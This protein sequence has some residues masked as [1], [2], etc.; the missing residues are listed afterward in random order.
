M[1]KAIILQADKHCMVLTA[2]D[3]FDDILPSWKK[4]HHLPPCMHVS[5]C[6]CVCVCVYNEV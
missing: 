4:V 5:V 3:E 2:Q 6:V 1:K